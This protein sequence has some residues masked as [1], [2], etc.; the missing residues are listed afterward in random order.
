MQMFV[1]S[2]YVYELTEKATLVGVVAIAQGLPVLA[3]SL[4][5][6]ALADRVN[7]RNV[8]IGAYL[9]SGMASLGI[10]VVVSVGAIQ[11]WHLVLSSA[12]GGLG[13][14]LIGGARQSVIAELV[15]REELLNA[16]SLTNTAQ[17][18]S[19]LAAPAVAGFVVASAV[20]IGGVFYVMTGL[21]FAA[22]VILSSIPRRAFRS[23]IRRQSVLKDMG[24]GLRYVRNNEVIL[25]LTV[26]FMVTAVFGMPYVYLLPVLAKEAWSSEPQQIGLLFSA[27]GAGA[28]VGSLSMA[29]LGNFQR[30]G[31]LLI[32]MA[33]GFGAG[34]VA[35]TFSPFYLIGL[36]VLFPL[37]AFQSA[38]VGLNASL[39]QLNSPDEIR[40]RVMGIY[41]MEIG[42]HPLGVLA[43][44]ALADLVGPQIAL[45]V[46]G[47]LMVLFLAYVYQRKRFIRQLP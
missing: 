28:V 3:F 19:R 21:Y 31:L 29:S 41:H 35:L 17:N 1:R 33:V 42:V 40:G 27:V 45:A 47:G 18:I 39:V 37:G 9:L 10:A 2:W 15:S 34:I 36:I 25:W 46:G 11:W 30:K 23:G 4:F 5:G 26:I 24:E 8:L 32:I 38:R 12:T 16:V 22:A 13:I 43:V 44:G 20:G 14:A 7:K 6:G